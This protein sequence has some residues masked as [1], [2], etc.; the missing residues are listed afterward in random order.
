ME[1][2]SIVPCTQAGLADAAAVEAPPLYGIFIYDMDQQTQ[3]PIVKPQEGVIYT[4]IVA[5]DSRTPPKPLYDK[6]DAGQTNKTFNNSLVTE[7]VGLLHIRSIYDVDGLDTAVPDIATVADPAQTLAADR[8]QRFLRLIKQVT[9][10]DRD[11]LNFPSSAY[12]VTRAYGMREII[13][14]TPI[15]PDG[16][17]QV[18]VPA[19]VPVS[20]EVVDADGRKLERNHSF[21]LQFRPGEVVACNGC[22]DTDSPL[23]HGRMSAAPPAVNAGIEASTPYPNTNAHMVSDEAE[24]TMAQIRNEILCT[25]GACKPTMDLIFNDV[26]T[27]SAV[28]TPDPDILIRY[29]DLSTAQPMSNALCDSDWNYR[30]LSIIHYE[31]H[32]HPLWSVNREVFDDTDTLIDDH[33]C[34]NCHTG[35][36]AGTAVVPEAQLDLT[37]GVFMTDSGQETDHFAA[38]RELLYPDYV[39]ELNED[40]QLV[41]LLVP[42]TDADGNQLYQTDED[43]NQV[44]D[45]DNNPI[46]L[47]DL[48]VLVD[49]GPSMIAGSA[50]DSRFLGIFDPGGTHEGYMTDAEMRL[51]AEWLDIGAQYYNNPFDVPLD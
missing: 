45:S 43:G 11:V 35:D 41:N 29:D 4:D 25:S 15:D 30:C 19:N 47:P 22:H 5:A 13:G 50:A 48:P 24:Q 39:Q 28:R 36:N 31:Q 7:Q 32:I 10:P 38:Y 8:Q 12:G 44:L 27:D 23:P 1:G 16:S 17:V 26:W 37:D 33:T 18:Q 46:P 42:Q 14:Y 51:I 2:T 21:S 40:G 3:L 49:G 9:I 6:E 20:F 34:I